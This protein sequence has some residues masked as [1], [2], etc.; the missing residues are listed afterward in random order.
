MI[1]EI[2]ENEFQKKIKDNSICVV[3]F[4]KP[5]CPHC[6]KTIAGVQDLVNKYN[7]KASFY[8]ANVLEADSLVEKYQI[9]AAPTVLFFKNGKLV[10]SRSG[11]THPLVM[12]DILGGL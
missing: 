5:Q 6:L 9:T 10:K 8:K 3:I 4:E 7:E 2:A 12:E 1:A 11:Y